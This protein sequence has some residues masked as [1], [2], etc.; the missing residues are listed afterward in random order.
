MITIIDYEMGNL[1]SLMNTFQFLGEKVKITDSPKEIEKAEKLVFPGVG[2]FG[3]A[4]ENLKRKKLDLAIKKV[5][6]KER[7]F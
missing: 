1:Q 6:A 7:P 5:L 3:K 4:M 2:N